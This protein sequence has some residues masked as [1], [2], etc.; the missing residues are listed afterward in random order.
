MTFLQ[1]RMSDFNMSEKIFLQS[2]KG[3]NVHFKDGFQSNS[4][5]PLFYFTKRT[6]Y[7]FL[8]K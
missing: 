3:S 7:I 8:K 1:P 2:S 4:W 5:P 6:V